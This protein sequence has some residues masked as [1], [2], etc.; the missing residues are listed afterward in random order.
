MIFTTDE[1]A[2][3]AAA[4][5]IGKVVVQLRL[6]TNLRHYLENAFAIGEKDLV[7]RFD[8]LLPTFLEDDEDDVD[9][10]ERFLPA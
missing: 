10:A 5:R 7:L 8:D 9:D 4:L 6:E 3:G 2:D 1:N